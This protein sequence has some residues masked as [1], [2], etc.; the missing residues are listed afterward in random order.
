MKKKWK[1]GNRNRKR[2]GKR[3]NGRGKRLFLWAAATF[4]LV[5]LAGGAVLGFLFFNKEKA[6]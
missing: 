3:K 1:S 6:F 5:L 4:A 2:G